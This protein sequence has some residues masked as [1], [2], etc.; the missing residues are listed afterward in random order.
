[1]VWT[2]GVDAQ[3]FSPV[4]TPLETNANP[5]VVCMGNF[6]L[7]SKRQDL[8]LQIFSMVRNSV[9]AARLFFVGHG[10]YEKDCRKLAE[11]LGLAE[12]VDFVGLLERSEVLKLLRTATVFLHCSESEGLP[13]VLLEAQA[14]G[15][16]VVASD[17][18]ANREALAPESRR[19][20]FKQDC[21]ESGATNV[22]RLLRDPELR[23]R[24]GRVGRQHVQD[25]FDTSRCLAS[26]EK[27]YKTLA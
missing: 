7:R 17:I 15:V 1:M 24:L 5:K 16:P 21:L 13:N 14:V 11:E 3:Y 23:R 19:Y 4:E 18:P 20:V 9:P 2:A 8:A 26:L 25:H 22:V 10:T 6:F 12:T 27:L